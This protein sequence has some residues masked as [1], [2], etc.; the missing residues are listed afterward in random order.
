MS[1]WSE[2]GLRRAEVQEAIGLGLSV[3]DVREWAPFPPFEI[4]WA[5]ARGL[6]LAQV[7]IW[8]ER[9]VRV[10]DAVEA[11]RVG[12]SL[13]ELGRWEAHGFNAADAWEAKETGVDIPQAIAWREAGF[14][15]P[16]ALQLIRDRWRLEDAVVARFEGVFP[17][18]R[19]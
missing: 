4:H 1:R 8:A 9:G 13:D 3:E 19:S 18:G 12:L 2:T 14:V 7:R 17:Y 15:V 16:D 11:T 6:S 5:R 10:R